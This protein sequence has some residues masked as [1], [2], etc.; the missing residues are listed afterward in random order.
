[1]PQSKSQGVSL[2]GGLEIVA[3]PA[4][5]RP[6]DTT[7][8]ASGDLVANSTTAGSVLALAFSIFQKRGDQACGEVV[9]FRLMKSTN[10][11]TNAAFRLHLFS[12]VPTFAS[13]GDNS[14]LSS[15]VV[16]SAKGYLGFMDI[17][18]M[19]GFSDVA[20]GIGAPDNSRQRLPFV[21]PNVVSGGPGVMY[22]FLEARG[23][24]T[25]GNAEVFTP[26]IIVAQ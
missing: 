23:A 22:G 1:M 6:A 17:T 4:F 8:Y 13:A 15:V 10:S 7:A 19:T 11:A 25:P 3:A 24:Y 26:S 2:A 16:A 21:L 18:A 9:G 14:A 5:T 20:W 12:V